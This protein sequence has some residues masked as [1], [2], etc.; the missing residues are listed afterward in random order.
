MC[1]LHTYLTI[2]KGCFS[3]DFRGSVGYA[4]DWWSGGLGSIPAGSGNIL[5]FG[6]ILK[7]FLR[8]FSPY[9]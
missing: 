9:R 1:I 7:Y 2:R 6:L 4:C 8:S 5:S 3:A